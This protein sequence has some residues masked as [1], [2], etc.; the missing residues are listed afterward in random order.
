MNKLTEIELKHLSGLLI[1]TL[2]AAEIL[3]RKIDME[4]HKHHQCVQRDVKKMCNNAL[5]LSTKL[6]RA[7]DGITQLG[8][9][10]GE[11]EGCKDAGKVFD[12]I[13]ADAGDILHLVM[14]Y[15]NAREYDETALLK[16]VSYA[17][18]MVQ[19]EQ[20]FSSETIADVVPKV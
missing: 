11:V 18:T 6:G 19:G 2:Q 17:K 13:M 8:I 5:A 20:I 3:N 16:M 9:D 12:A 10:C 15:E 4:L 14:E 7:L 1:L